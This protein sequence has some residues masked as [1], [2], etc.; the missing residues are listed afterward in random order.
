MPRHYESSAAL[1]PYYRCEE[2]TLQFCDGFERVRVVRLSFRNARDAA[3]L[4]KK[5]CRSEW[6]SCP[7][8]KILTEGAK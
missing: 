2:A 4:K 3:S 6:T 5:Y 8:A 1:C 7:L